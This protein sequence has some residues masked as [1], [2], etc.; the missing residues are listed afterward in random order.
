MVHQLLTEA[1]ED[2]YHEA[3]PWRREITRLHLALT[4][5][6]LWCAYDQVKKINGHSVRVPRP[7]PEAGMHSIA[8]KEIATWPRSVGIKLGAL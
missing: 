6:R 4:G 1:G 3:E 2:P 5:E 8:Q 7:A